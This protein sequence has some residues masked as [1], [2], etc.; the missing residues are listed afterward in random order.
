MNDRSAFSSFQS[1]SDGY[2]V[3]PAKSEQAKTLRRDTI[4]LDAL[5][6]GNTRR[7][8]FTNFWYVPDVQEEFRVKKP[9]YRPQVNAGISTLQL[10]H[11]RM[12]HQNKLHVVKVADCEHGLQRPLD[13]ELC[14]DCIFGKKKHRLLFRSWDRRAVQPKYK[15]DDT[16]INLPALI[17]VDT[18]NSAGQ[19]SK[20]ID[21]CDQEHCI[22]DESSSAEEADD[23]IDQLRNLRDRLKL[24]EPVKLRTDY[25][26]SV[27]AMIST[28]V[29]EPES[30]DE[31]CD[32]PDKANLRNW[33]SFTQPEE[34]NF[35]GRQ[36]GEADLPLLE[37]HSI[38]YK[39]SANQGLLRC[40][41]G[42]DECSNPL[43]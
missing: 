9:Q 29:C 4:N 28:Q 7:M 1:F 20:E 25:V 12:G 39:S 34:A 43:L 27:V 30:F 38:V 33:C 17:N 6:N 22:D 14:E 37:L 16:L 2:N 40:Y 32:S 24:P 18:P 41:S 5:I 3:T 31:S 19:L 10:M 36:P 35:R 26:M 42:A 8:Q 21:Q 13:S 15:L 23:A 11:E